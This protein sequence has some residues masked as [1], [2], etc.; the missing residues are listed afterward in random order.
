MAEQPQS[1]IEAPPPAEKPFGARNEQTLQSAFSASPIYQGLYNDEERKETYQEL[2]MN[3]TVSNGLG[4]NSFNRD[5]EGTATDPTPSLPLTNS[6]MSNANIPSTYVPNLNSAPGAF[7]GNQEPYI[8][9][10]PQGG[11]EF[12]SGLEAQDVN[13]EYSSEQIAT[14][15]IGSYIM[16]ESYNGSS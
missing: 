8:G 7:Y 14:H 5:F 11:N 12:G 16:G 2:A 3:G 4:I 13:P 9:P 6:E 1:I 10:V 15:T